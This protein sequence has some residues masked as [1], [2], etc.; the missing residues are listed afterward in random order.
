LNNG[1]QGY[2]TAM[3]ISCFMLQPAPMKTPVAM[4]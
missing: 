4:G 2:C 1:D 3:A